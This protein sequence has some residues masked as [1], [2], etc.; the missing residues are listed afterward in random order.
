MSTIDLA[1]QEHNIP[2]GLPTEGFISMVASRMKERNLS[3][4]K[5][6]D[7]VLPF[8]SELCG[9]CLT[10]ATWSHKVNR[11]TCNRCGA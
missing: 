7:D 11:W 10:P 9:D 2:E 3:L 4:D 6:I 5:A 1:L 8:W